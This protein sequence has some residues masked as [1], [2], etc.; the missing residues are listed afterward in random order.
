MAYQLLFF[1]FKSKNIY[2]DSNLIIYYSRRLHCNPLFCFYFHT[3]C[4]SLDKVSLSLLLLT[5]SIH[6]QY[7]I[8]TLLDDL[9]QQI[10]QYIQ[11][12]LYQKKLSMF[13]LI[14]LCQLRI[15]AID[16]FLKSNAIRKSQTEKQKLH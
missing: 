1:L 6:C 4:N 7:S 8:E 14:L 9:R 3:I 10:F 11:P 15:E 16:S 2:L 13:R 5:T 12:N